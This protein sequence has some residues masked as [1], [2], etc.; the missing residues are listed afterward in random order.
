MFAISQIPEVRFLIRPKHSCVDCRRQ[1]MRLAPISRRV[2]VDSPVRLVPHTSKSHSA[3]SMRSTAM[4]EL[5]CAPSFR[6][7]R[8]RNSIPGSTDFQPDSPC[9]M[10]EPWAGS[11]CHDKAEAA[12]KTTRTKPVL[13]NR[14]ISVGPPQQAA[15]LSLLGWLFSD[16]FHEPERAMTVDD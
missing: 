10:A 5:F 9:A 1:I 2:P 13:R 11:F 7:S 12:A 16:D 14:F 6:A 4:R 8:N 15:D 3:G